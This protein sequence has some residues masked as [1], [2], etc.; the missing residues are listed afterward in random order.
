MKVTIDRKQFAKVLASACR[1]APR[2]KK[3]IVA[4]LSHVHI[5][6]H[7]G[8][9]VVTA[10]NLDVTIRTVTPA[11]TSELAKGDRLLVPAHKLL[12]AVKRLGGDAVK[13][14]TLPN[15]RVRLTAAGARVDIAGLLP[16]EYVSVPDV[17]TLDVKC[18]APELSWL[19]SRVSYAV[20]GD[21]PASVGIRAGASLR[22]DGGRLFMCANDGHRLAEA[23]GPAVD[24]ASHWLA[25]GVILT[26]D[27]LAAL[28]GAASSC[29]SVRL[30]FGNEQLHAQ[31]GPT[32][33]SLCVLPKK[34][35][36][37]YRVPA[38]G[39]LRVQVSS[40]Q[41]ASAVNLAML[42]GTGRVLIVLTEAALIV[43][44]SSGAAASV[45]TPVSVRSSEGDFE[46][47]I[48]S[49]FLLETIKR[50]PEVVEL[51]IDP[52][53]DIALVLRDPEDDTHSHMIARFEL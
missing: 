28:H 2:P 50:T 42:A 29:E 49:S 41:L 32:C 25:R 53:D 16:D 51:C 46:I 39:A 22:E 1:I 8:A 52:D 20:S 34:Y 6:G 21:D 5:V 36:R 48:N 38:P 26:R 27:A 31:C 19:I 12:D 43:T 13:L 7:S 14:S 3:S 35:P 18:P 17:P 45:R 11:E 23:R 30:G 44:S 9:V 15:S 4:A 37:Q 10:S 40:A 33:L 47:L 24:S